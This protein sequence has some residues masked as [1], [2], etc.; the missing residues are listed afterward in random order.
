MRNLYPPQFSGVA[1]CRCECCCGAALRIH[2]RVRDVHFG[3]PG[4][5]DYEACTN[6]GF[7]R[8]YPMPTED[9]LAAFYSSYY[10]RC[11]KPRTFKRSG[12]RSFLKRAV[13]SGAYGYSAESTVEKWVGH[14]LARCAPLRERIGMQIMF[15]GGESPGKL[16]DVG[17]GV[18][19]FLVIM[20]ELGWDVLGVEAD[21]K[22]ANIA[23]QEFGLPVIA[24]SLR[25]AMLPDE[26]IDVIT[27]G[28]VIEHISH[29]EAVLREALRILKPGGRIVILTPNV[30]SL[31]H[32]IF[33][34]SWQHLSPPYHVQLFSLQGLLFMLKQVGFEPKEARTSA[35]C[36]RQ[37]WMESV[38]SR[39]AQGYRARHIV[40]ALNSLLFAAV[41]TAACMVAPNSGEE[42][43]FEGIKA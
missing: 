26:S 19:F 13:L 18:G 1:V 43:V 17:C 34:A 4:E 32:R 22:T 24:G 2:R 37:T 40:D 12:Y 39:R 33:G 42:L 41:E 25:D 16:L 21:F 6:C 29:P 31:G 23:R 5:W 38:K 35:R 3:T 11:E 15:L 9:E 20:R 7:A 28:H 30:R 36:A 10:P 8:I 27:M 14:I